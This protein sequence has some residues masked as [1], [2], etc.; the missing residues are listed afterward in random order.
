MARP[1]E[2]DEQTV[3]DAA[4]N[5]FWANGVA[6]TSISDLGAATGLSVGSIYKAFES[7]AG[8]CRASLDDYLQHGLA[9]ATELLDHAEGPVA[10]LAAWLDAMA[11]Q[12]AS[13]SPTRGCFAVNCATEL[14]ETDDHVRERL[15]RHDRALRS[16]VRQAISKAVTSGELNVDPSAGAMLLCTTVNGLQ[17]ESRKGVSPDD[18]RTTLTMAFD[19]LR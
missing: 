13:T 6:E 9:A 8:L 14:A 1:R 11:V 10:G 18:A 7:K 16:V 17:V 3:L 12:A 2:F 15:R 4:R 19:A 5:A